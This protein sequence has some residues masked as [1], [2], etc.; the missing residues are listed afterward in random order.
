VGLLLARDR[1]EQVALK[2]GEV[3]HIPK[4]VIPMLKYVGW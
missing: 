3:V 4:M 1:V 2:A